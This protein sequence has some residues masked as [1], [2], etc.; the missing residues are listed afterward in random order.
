MRAKRTP[1]QTDLNQLVLDFYSIGE[2]LAANP[3]MIGEAVVLDSIAPVVEA[4]PEPPPIEPAAPNLVAPLTLSPISTEQPKVETFE[5]LIAEG[6]TRSSLTERIESGTTLLH[7]MI[8]TDRLPEVPAKWLT[9][10]VLAIPDQAGNTPAHLAAAKGELHLLP[11]DELTPSLVETQNDA[12]QNLLQVAVAAK[13]LAQVPEELLDTEALSQLDRAGHS[14]LEYATASGQAD[15]LPKALLSGHEEE[16]D[17]PLGASEAE[18]LVAEVERF[19]EVMREVL[20]PEEADEDLDVEAATELE[21]E[22][23]ADLDEEVEPAP[24]EDPLAA[25]YERMAKEAEERDP[26]PEPV[27]KPVEELTAEDL[28]LADRNGETPLFAAILNGEVDALTPG[29]ITEEACLMQDSVG[30]TAAH[31]LARYSGTVPEAF[32]SALTEAVLL[33]TDY[34]GTAAIH[35]FAKEGM[36]NQL[37]SEALTYRVLTT[38]DDSGCTAI[39]YAEEVGVPCNLEPEA[40]EPQPRVP[41]GYRAPA[42]AAASPTYSPS[43]GM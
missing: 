10:D 3:A 14:A 11:Q 13:T 38:P 30:N 12:G 18:K 29:I 21:P 2:T 19:D 1:V 23:E 42:Y 35:E 16:A 31:L 40:A 32:H 26:E 27:A 34:N 25:L 22:D 17:Q 7:Y 36:I 5:E 37:P 8:A 9:A 15:C 33:T 43:A 20:H 4:A 39:Q 6:L 28:L 41:I 24:E